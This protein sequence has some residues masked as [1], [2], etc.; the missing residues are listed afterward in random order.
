MQHLYNLANLRQL[1]SRYE[2]PVI[3]GQGQ[4]GAKLFARN[5]LYV[6]ERLQ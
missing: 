2:Q 1:F 5:L 4:L 3:E 6:R